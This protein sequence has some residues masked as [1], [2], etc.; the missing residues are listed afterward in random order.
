M[1]K[2]LSILLGSLAL[3]LLCGCLPEERFWWAPDG[4][5]ALVRLPDGLHVARA[6]GSLSEALKL[7]LGSEDDL[8]S[9]VS[10]LPDGNGFVVNRVRT[11]ATWAEVLKLLPESEVKEV[12][13]LASAIPG[14][15]EVWAATGADGSTPD[16]V[17]GWLPVKD[18][19]TLSAAF[20]RA[21]E[22][23]KES[24][25]AVLRRAPKGEEILEELHGNTRPF[26]VQELCLVK[27]EGDAVVAEP[28]PLTRSL[29]TILFPKV[30]PKHRA[31]AYF[32]GLADGE[33]AALEVVSLDG[34]MPLLVASGI[35]ASH[36]WS[37]DGR[38]LV[39]VAPVLGKADAPLKRIQRQK[40][41][42]DDGVPLLP[43]G[44]DA[45][46]ERMLQGPVNL[47]LAI[48]AGTPRVISL[49][50][51]RVL[52]ASQPA[53]LPV[54]GDGL[55]V[56]P[57][58]YTVTPDGKKV[59]AVSTAPGDLPA[60]LGFYAV[61]PDGRRL[62][63]V[64]SET[65]A[66]AV[67]DLES[68]RTEILSPAHPDWQG[69]T[70]PQWKSAT[71]LTFAALHDGSPQWMLWTEGGGVKCI[72]NTWKPSGTSGWLKEKKPEPQ[73]ASAP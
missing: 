26:H 70:M 7:E 31:V 48:I 49:P 20:Y 37:P 47:A 55:E 36:D 21:C 69:R 3:L 9:R 10:W 59:Q 67:V 58:L 63:V 4:A 28:V 11:F 29:R 32:H 57:L 39:Y 33:S 65:D 61:S 44:G 17:L 30:S 18:K 60:N 27:I 53:T 5:R 72:S 51:G 38:S 2:P 41:L 34:G 73:P 54:A 71:E 19:E 42:G 16:T 12:E 40:V 68:G 46:H 6:D 13:Q 14:M 24:M 45:L 64:E 1:K 43:A 56:A 8:P 62:A 50:D 35:S 15:L 22:L 52:F 23:K 66:L 25:E